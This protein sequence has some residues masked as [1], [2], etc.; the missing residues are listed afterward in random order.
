MRGHRSSIASVLS[1][2]RG[3]IQ[4]LAQTF[5]AGV[6]EAIRGAS[7]EDIIGESTGAKRG[8][9]RPPRTTTASAAVTGRVRC[10]AKDIAALSESI[11]A[12]VRKNP[13]GLRAEQIRGELKIAKNEWLRPLAAALASKKLKKKGEKRC[14]R[15]PRARPGACD[16]PPLESPEVWKLAQ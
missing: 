3:S 1:D 2:L 12:F 7:L 8:P 10:S 15:G 5:A 6:L 16:R 9:G 4:A 11:V 13:N 14:S